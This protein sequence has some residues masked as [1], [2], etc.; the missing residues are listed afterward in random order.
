M[1]YTFA[2]SMDDASGLQTSG[3]FGTAFI[4]NALRQE[5]N[6]SVSDFD[7]AH[8][9]NVNAIWDIPIGR[10]RTFFKGM[11]RAVDAIFGGWQLSTIYRFNTGYPDG[12]YFDIYG[13]PTNWNVRS[14]M[15]QLSDV[16]MNPTRSGGPDNNRPNAFS[17]RLATYR[18]FRS[19]APGESGDRNLIRRPSFWVMD[20]GLQKGFD[21]PWNENHKIKIRWDVFNVTNSV[22]FAGNADRT[23][24]LDPNLQGDPGPSFGNF[25]FTQQNPR[26]MQ[27]AFRFEF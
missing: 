4:L 21:M 1:N 10:N 22:S 25:T 17:D 16:R 24:G 15:V 12:Y 26:I 14:A 2:K 11:N 7:I 23:F 8:I 6:R 27:F 18:S 20:A 19:P 9:V 13:W 5:D 3:V